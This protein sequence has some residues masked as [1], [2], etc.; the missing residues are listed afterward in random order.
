M[1]RVNAWDTLLQ[2]RAIENQSFAIGVNRTGRDGYKAD[3]NGHS[4][5]INYLGEYVHQPTEG[6]ETSVVK[7]DKQPMLKFREKYN[8]Q[9]EADQFTIQ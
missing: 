6:N 2:A 3:Y 4:A 8:F 1:P 5:V 9:K 7:I